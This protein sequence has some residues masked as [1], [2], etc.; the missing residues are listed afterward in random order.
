[1]TPHNNK[2]LL[3]MSGGLD[4]SAAAILLLKQGYEVI[5][6][7]LEM[8]NENS[9]EAGVVPEEKISEA[10]H[11]ARQLGIKHYT[12]NVREA[13]QNLV[14]DDFL[15]EYF[16]GRTP[17]PCIHCNTHIKWKYL[18]QKANELN[19]R[20][21]ATGHYAKLRKTD[22][23]YHLLKA[24]DPKKD[25]SYF[26]WG[27]KQT[28]LA[29]TLFPLG[30]TK[31]DDL[32]ALVSGYN[33]HFLAKKAESMEVCFIPENDY[34]K[35]LKR[36]HPEKMEKLKGGIFL[37]TTGEILGKHKG[38]PFY[39]IGQRK[40]LEIAVGYPLYVVKIIPESN[41]V[42]LGKREELYQKECTA[43]HLNFV[44]FPGE[45]QVLIK[46]RY[47]HAGELGWIMREKNVLHIRFNNPVFAIAPGQ[48]AVFYDKEELLGG[49]IID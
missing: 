17:N 40:G 23:K 34:R 2:V 49:G 14:I 29:R 18:L 43:S 33:L 6:F 48:S 8:Y 24:S 41:T 44:N 37:S 21:I 31:K 46:I 26:L 13:F 38:Y 16:S 28:I 1:M 36:M 12:Q 47:N 42:V 30:N 22:D 4:S 3:A 25:Q 11:I 7:T 27:L 9:S 45:K 20:Y 10:R 32:S 39:T 15:D 19:C 5:G 35:F